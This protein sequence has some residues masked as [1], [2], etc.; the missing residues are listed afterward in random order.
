MTPD[1]IEELSLLA[2][3]EQLWRL[4]ILDQLG[5]T[6]EKRQQLDTCVALRRYASHL[7]ELQQ[8]LETKCSVLITPL[9]SYWTVHDIV[10][11][12]LYHENLRPRNKS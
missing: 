6:V 3:T 11:T 5:L 12:P 10:E 8:A 2:D 1:Y 7:R 9:T 4:P